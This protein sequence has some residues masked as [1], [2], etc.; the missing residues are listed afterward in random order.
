MI[1]ARD[2]NSKNLAKEI[3]GAVLGTDHFAI[4]RSES[5]KPFLAPP[6]EGLQFNLTHTR[7]VTLFV[8]AWGTRVGIDVEWR[9]R[10]VNVEPLAKRFLSAAE[11]VE[12]LASEDGAE[13]RERFLRCWTRKEALL[14]AIGTGL[15]G[16][17][18]KFTVSS[19]KRARIVHCDPAIFGPAESWRLQDLDIG[20]DYFASVAKEGREEPKVT[21]FRW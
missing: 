18:E 14:K 15:A 9:H 1:V 2:G 10:D 13:R 16:G 3:V 7:D 21:Y 4:V 20:P 12:I 19:G 17:L 6:R 8:F 11:R 5:G